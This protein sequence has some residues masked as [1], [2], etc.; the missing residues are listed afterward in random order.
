VPPSERFFGGGSST[1]RGFA[2]NDLGP[3]LPDGQPLG[4]QSLLFLN[5]ELRA[6][7]YKFFDTAAFTDIGNVWAKASA[8]SLSDLRKTAGFGIRIRNPFIMIRFDYGWI[9]GRRPGESKGAFHF[10]IGQAF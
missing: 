1:I 4:G 10:S 9:L 3:K 2:Q 7:V 5:L 8:F 6:P